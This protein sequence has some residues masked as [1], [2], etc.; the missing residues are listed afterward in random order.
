LWRGATDNVSTHE[1]LQ[2]YRA[3]L[4]PAMLWFNFLPFQSDT[5]S[6]L[7]RHSHVKARCSCHLTDT[8]LFRSYLMSCFWISRKQQ[9]AN[10]K[11]HDFILPLDEIPFS[12]NRCPSLSTER[13]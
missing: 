11:Q 13:N 5:C 2:L 4:C 6:S 8:P 12:I 3:V 1:F 7:I 10:H 9:S